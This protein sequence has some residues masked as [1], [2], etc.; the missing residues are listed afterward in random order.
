MHGEPAR[1]HRHDLDRLPFSF[2]GLISF[3]LVLAFGGFVYRKRPEARLLAAASLWF[4]PLGG[5]ASFVIFSFAQTYRLEILVVQ[6]A[7]GLVGA[8]LAFAGA[9]VKRLGLRI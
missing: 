9:A 5:V 8:G 1:S 3:G 7:V 6:G 4:S 2:L